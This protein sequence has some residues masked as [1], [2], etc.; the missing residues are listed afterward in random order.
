MFDSEIQGRSPRKRSRIRKAVYPVAGFGTRLLPATKTSPKEMLTLVD[1]P[2]IQHAVEEARDAGIEEHILV[3]ARGKEDLENHFDSAPALEA[4]LASQGKTDLLSRVREITLPSGSIAHV[5]QTEPKGL[6]HAIWCAR[7]LVRGEPFAV[8]LP[9][10]II[11]AARPCLEQMIEAADALPEDSVLMAVEDVP[12][13]AIGRYGAVSIGNDDGRLVGVDGIVEK[14]EP[15]RAPSLTGVVGR[16]ILSPDIM[17]RLE[18]AIAQ[19]DAE[20]MLTDILSKK[21]R[22]SGSVYGFRFHGTRHDCGSRQGY[23]RA[24]V[25]HALVHPELG[26]DFRAWLEGMIER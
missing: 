13:D 10:D 11:Q 26:Q 5:R 7:H 14:P 22:L 20:V 3:T 12:E 15:G 1:R 6:A 18:A 19:Q 4:E 25:S 16:Y 21:A 2:L 17:T 8:I 23:L 9:D 24:I